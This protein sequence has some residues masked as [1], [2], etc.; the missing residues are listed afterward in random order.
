MRGQKIPTETFNQTIEDI[1]KAF[2]KDEIKFMSIPLL[3]DGGKH[4]VQVF[5]DKE[6]KNIEYYD[7]RLSDP[8]SEIINGTN[9]TVS[10]LMDTLNTNLFD[11]TA[12]IFINQNKLQNDFH[13]CGIH[14]LDV[15]IKRL[16]NVQFKDLQHARNIGDIAKIR[17]DLFRKW[18]SPK[19]MNTADIDLMN[20]DT[21]DDF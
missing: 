11:S 2:S 1:V 18:L 14:I 4:V 7:L 21:C 20:D 12:N 10:A 9:Q 5:I 13:N 16:D 3:I 17:E 15:T 19:I 8:K 6:A